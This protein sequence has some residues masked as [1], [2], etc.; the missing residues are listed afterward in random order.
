MMTELEIAEQICDVLKDVNLSLTQV[1]ALCEA[2]KIIMCSKSKIGEYKCA[3]NITSS[4]MSG[5][6]D[7][8]CDTCLQDEIFNLIKKHGVKTVGSCCGHGVKQGFI[9]VD[10]Y[11]ANIM[12][13]LGYERLSLDE[14][15][16]GKNCFK[17][18]T[19]L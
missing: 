18:K 12:E 6:K 15:G 8:C 17:P 9:Q 16:N 19:N 4:P 10:D 11:S 7:M 14:Y 1:R 2:R 5:L 13:S 3:V